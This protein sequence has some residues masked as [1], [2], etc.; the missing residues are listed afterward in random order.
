MK[1]SLIVGLV[2]FLL[3]TGTLE[4]SAQRSAGGSDYRNAIG[5]GIDFGDGST[6]VGPSFETLFYREPRR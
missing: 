2:A 5:L 3:L 1:K 6:L 4:V